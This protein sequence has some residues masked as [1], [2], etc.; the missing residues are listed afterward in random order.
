MR[1]I[2]LAIIIAALL[3]PCFAE[4]QQPAEQAPAEI[5]KGL[6]NVVDVYPNIPVSSL[7]Y[8]KLTQLPDGI[9]L[10]CGDF[11]I[12]A[13]DFKKRIAGEHRLRTAA[14]NDLFYMLEV[15]ADAEIINKEAHK[16]YA[17]QIGVGDYINTFYGDMIAKMKIEVTDEEVEKVVKSLNIPAEKLD[18]ARK[19]IRINIGGRKNNFARRQIVMECGKRQ[20][21]E[22]SETWVKEALE[23]TPPNSVEEARTKGKPF[24][25]IFISSIPF[26]AEVRKTWEPVIDKVVADYKGRVEPLYIIMEQFPCVAQRNYADLST[27]A[28]IIFFDKTG[29]EVSRRTGY[30][31]EEDLRTE[32]EKISK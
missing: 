4:E 22:V 18:E 12:K 20:L 10:R 23:K 17:G 30:M 16:M 19:G 31:T 24:V 26:F 15:I 28:E 6:P 21:I 5:G 2:T 1:L 11:V 8:A 32:M 27:A 9:V 7:T 29:K 25:A 14:Q 13:D 3:C